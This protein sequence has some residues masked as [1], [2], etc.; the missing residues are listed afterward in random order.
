MG[1]NTKEIA[2]R[3]YKR[4]RQKRKRFAVLLSVLFLLLLVFAGVLA[5]MLTPLFNVRNIVVEGNKLVSSTD[6]VNAL[7]TDENSKIFTIDKG[8]MK[9]RVETLPYVKS[10]KI[11]RRIW[12]SI[13]VEIEEAKVS[14]YIMHEKNAYLFDETGKIVNI[15]GEAMSGVPEIRGCLMTPK[16]VGEKI[17]V[18]SGEKLDTILLFASEF[19]SANITDK[20]TMLDVSDILNVCG[21]Y[22]NRYDIMFGSESGLKEKIAIMV[23]AIGHNA[24][25]EMGTVDLR[26]DGNAYVKPERTFVKN[27]LEKAQETEEQ[28]ESDTEGEGEPEAEAEEPSGDNTA[29]GEASGNEE[30]GNESESTEESLAQNEEESE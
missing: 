27:A 5:S 24:E 20:M 25:N 6:I 15:T 3:H 29:G 28:E 2:D 30:D 4:Q 13:V 21:I 10:A 23:K 7:G 9:K 26:I 8:L 22:D 1:K 16:S 11:Q 12:G 19:D 18:D 17:S 14:G